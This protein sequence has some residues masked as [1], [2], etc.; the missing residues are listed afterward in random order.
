MTNSEQ[1]TATITLNVSTNPIETLYEM[2]A[3]L[4]HFTDSMQDWTAENEP[5]EPGESK[6]KIYGM[7]ALICATMG[8]AM[9]QGEPNM[10]ETAYVLMRD[11]SKQYITN[12]EEEADA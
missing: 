12:P 8:L 11:L 1:P 7:N 4:A 9:Q 10:L 3:K 2:Y 5:G 6:A